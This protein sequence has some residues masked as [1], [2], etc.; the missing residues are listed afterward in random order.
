MTERREKG[1]CFNYDERFHHNHK[2]KARFLL[3]IADRED[4][5]LINV[6]EAVWEDSDP[7]DAGD[8]TQLA[9][10][11][12]HAMSRVQ[13]GQTFRVMGQIC[14]S[15]VHVLVDGGSSLNFIQGRIAHSLG[16]AHSLSPTLKVLVGNGEELISTKV[17]KGVQLETQ[18]HTFTM[19]LYVLNLSGPDVVLGTPWLKG[20]GPVIMDYASLTMQFTVGLDSITLK[21]ETGPIPTSISYRQLKKLTTHDPSTQLFSLHISDLSI[22]PPV[23]P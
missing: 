2:C 14:Q 23:S 12:L 15:P 21:G 16:L 11:G 20:L 10:L 17:C 13:T 4:T 22:T 1:L 18:G 5:N 6:D 8:P 9:H 7:S 3:L 19:D